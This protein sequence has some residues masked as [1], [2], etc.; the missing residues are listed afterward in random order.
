MAQRE[1]PLTNTLPP[2]P[3]QK[4]TRHYHLLTDAP[5]IEDRADFVYVPATDRKV[6]Q[7]EQMSQEVEVMRE[8]ID[9]LRGELREISD[10]FREFKRQF[11]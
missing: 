8:E 11:E 3:G 4:E 1:K 2:A 6:S 10:A 9:A 5:E 7:V